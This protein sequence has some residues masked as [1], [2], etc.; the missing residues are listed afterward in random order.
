MTGALQRPGDDLRRQSPRLAA[1]VRDTESLTGVLMRYTLR[2]QVPQGLLVFGVRVKLPGDEKPEDDSQDAQVAYELG[3]GKEV[4]IQEAPYWSA[5][6][7]LKNTRA[8]GAADSVAP[9]EEQ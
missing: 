2:L 9:A 4:G 3:L 6:A 7:M 1:G 8:P 5:S